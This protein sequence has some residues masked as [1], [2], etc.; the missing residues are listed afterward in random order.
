MSLQCWLIEFAESWP[1]K[2][3]DGVNHWVSVETV[4]TCENQN[5]SSLNDKERNI[6]LQKV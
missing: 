6:Q 5:T 4:M 1:K 3:L 2:L